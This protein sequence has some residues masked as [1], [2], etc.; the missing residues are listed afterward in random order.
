MRLVTA[1]GLAA[2]TDAHGRFHITCAIT[3]PRVA[4]ATSCSSSTT[5]RCR[6]ATVCRREQALVQR[7]TRGKALKFN[8]GA[9][10]HRVVGLDIADAVFE[11]G[12]TEMRD[13]VAAAAADCCSRS[14]RRHRR[15]CGCPTWPTSRMRSWSSGACRRSKQQITESW[16]ALDCGYQLTIEPEVFWRSAP[17]PSNPPCASRRQVIGMSKRH[18]TA[19]RCRAAAVRRGASA[20]RTSVDAPL[21]EAVERQL[22]RR[23]AVPAVDAATRRSSRPRRGDR[24]EIAAGRRARSSRPSSSTE[25]RAADPIRVRAW[26]T[27]RAATSSAREGPRGMRDRR[28]VRLH[29][30]GHADAQPL[31]AALARVY[32]DNAGLSRERA[33]EVAEFFQQAL[34]LPPE[35]I[36][37]EWAGDTRPI[38]TQRDRRRAGRST[39]ASRSRSGTTSR[40]RAVARGGSA[41]SR[42]TSSASRSAAWRRC[43]RC[44]SWKATRAARA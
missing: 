19:A 36:S 4:A 8:F 3:P 5:A 41:S 12:T 23:S 25:R 26:R 11:P 32:G 31:S 33:G 6:A 9:S 17:R 13:P 39:A 16:K 40:R 18:L 35:A 7:A 42:R 24:L 10:I 44:A 2:T 20:P 22:V 27:F 37:Y 43:A 28:N 21:G 14:C 15:C 1:R 30:V 38:A 34:A 29:L